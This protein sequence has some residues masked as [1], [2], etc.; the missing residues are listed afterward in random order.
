MNMRRYLMYFIT[1]PFVLFWL[2]VFLGTALMF[3]DILTRAFHLRG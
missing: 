3:F 1:L 2:T